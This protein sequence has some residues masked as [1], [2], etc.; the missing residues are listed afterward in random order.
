MKQT[1]TDPYI[2][3]VFA[4]EHDMATHSGQ[5]ISAQL[6]KGQSIR[7]MYDSD[8]H[9]VGYTITYSRSY[10]IGGTVA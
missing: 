10:S 3:E 5:I 6:R 2:R 8:D 4:P 1:Y 9:I 7:W